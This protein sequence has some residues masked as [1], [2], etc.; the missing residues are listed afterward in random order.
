M[1]WQITTTWFHCVEFQWHLV[2]I[3]GNVSESFNVF[4]WIYTSVLVRSLKRDERSSDHSLYL[5]VSLRRMEDVNITNT[6]LE[7]SYTTA[8]PGFS[9]VV[10]TCTI[11]SV[12]L[13]LNLVAL[14]AVYSL[15]CTSFTYCM[16][17]HH[18][19]HVFMYLFYCLSVM[20]FNPSNGQ[21]TGCSACSVKIN[22]II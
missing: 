13:P 9:V 3:V 8:N 12:G 6:M 2:F 17:H 4:V 10:V 14:Y 18:Y 16:Y 21:M 7:Q 19:H 11:I 5:Q 15:V 20:D 1:L 22:F